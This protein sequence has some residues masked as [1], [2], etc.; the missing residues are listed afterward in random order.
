MNSIVVPHDPAWAVAFQIEAQAIAR[1]MPDIILAIHHIGSTSVPCLAA[2]PIIDIL[3]EVSALNALDAASAPLEALG[4][5]VMGAFG[6]EGRRYFRKT[7]PSG[8]RTHH[9]H[10]FER[11]SPH[12]VRHLAFRDYLRRHPE[13]AAAYGAL[14]LALLAGG[15]SR[16]SYQAAKAPFVAAT[17]IE[18]LAWRQRDPN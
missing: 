9:L 18:A 13:K 8:R 7:D 2:K 12:L 15:E 5:E 16:E 17:E 11:S 6:I 4:Y 14:K 10:A 1:A 3:A